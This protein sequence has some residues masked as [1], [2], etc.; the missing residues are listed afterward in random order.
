M[1]PN[2]T[3]RPAKSSSRIDRPHYAGHLGP[4]VIPVTVALTTGWIGV[5]LL[6]VASVAALCWILADRDRSHRLAL[7]VTIWRDS[8]PADLN[9]VRIIETLT[10]ER[11]DTEQPAN[12]PQMS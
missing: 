5:A 12:S 7:L 2:T 6:I 11:S 4:A 3:S 9:R 1:T 8:T 10:A